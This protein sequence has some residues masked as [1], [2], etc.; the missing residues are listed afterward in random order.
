[1]TRYDA[2]DRSLLI[3]INYANHKVDDFSMVVPDAAW[4]KSAFTASGA[5]A[6]L[7]PAANGAM[8]VSFPLDRAD[9]VV[10]QR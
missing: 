8:R 2:A 10:L 5:K 7:Q 9:A 6:T 1:M 4:A 3:A